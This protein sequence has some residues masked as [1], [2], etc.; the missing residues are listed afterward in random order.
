MKKNQGFTLIEALLIF[1][2]AGLLGGTGWYV[3]NARNNANKSAINADS[4]NSSVAKSAKK[5]VADPTANW[6]AYS[7]KDGQF[8]LKYP[9]TW[10][11]NSCPD[12]TNPVLLMGPTAQTVGKCNSDF[13]GEILVTSVSGDKRSDYSLDVKTYPDVKKA[14]VTVA[15]VAG[16]KQTGTYTIAQGDQPALG[17]ANGTKAINYVFFTNNRTYII[18]YQQQPNYP[19]VSADLDMLVTKTLKFSP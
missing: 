1:V 15:Q 4:A 6:T 8:S 19:D 16:E 18:Q 3:W 2:I 10:S 5:V 12:A 11:Y 17:P 9:T 14:A 7:S 13:V